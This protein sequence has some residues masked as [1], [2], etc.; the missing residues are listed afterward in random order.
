MTAI[1]GVLN[2]HAIAVAADSA[3]TIGAGVKIYNKA[4]KIFTLSKHHPI[5]IA[6]Y[7]GAMFNGLVPWEIIIKMFRSQLGNTK[8]NTVQEYADTFF[9]YLESYKDEYI[10]RKDLD[11]VLSSEISHF[12]ISEII[13]KLPNSNSETGVDKDDVKALIHLLK[14]I[15]SKA[16]QARKIDCFAGVNIAEFKSSI[17]TT[18]L[19]PIVNQIVSVGG[20]AEDVSDLIC[21]TLFEVFSRECIQRKHYTGI[22]FFGYG[23]KE[24]Y[25]VLY[26]T[27]VFNSFAGKIYWAEKE[28]DKVSNTKPDAFICPMAQTDVMTTYITGISPLIENTFITS[29]IE[30]IK[31]ILSNIQNS[32]RA[33]NSD[34]STAIGQID[35]NPIVQSYVNGITKFKN[36]NA[37]SPL[38]NTIATMEKEDLAELAENLIYLTSLKRRITPDM[39]S[40]GGPV[41]VAIVSKGDGFI[42]IK[43]KHYF[44]PTLN[45]CYFETYFEN[46]NNTQ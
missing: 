43:R 10:E 33:F 17:S 21:E 16:C 7:S 35:I 30:A 44:D 28:V 12:W 41:D 46:E 11:A 40:V 5:G 14:D 26:Q 20:K 19:Q 2:K 38:M 29:T 31:L 4:N 22:A 42:W 32:V 6:I 37:I 27:M 18:L 23:E 24:I 15:K 34:L 3:E 8:Y 39:E 13:D 25:P 1:V 9:K 45:R 36:E